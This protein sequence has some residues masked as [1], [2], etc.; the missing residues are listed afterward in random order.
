MPFIR[1]TRVSPSLSF[2][3][4]TTR[5]S[6]EGMLYCR[7]RYDGALT[8]EYK[9]WVK[10]PVAIWPALPP[11]HPQSAVTL[12]ML[13]QIR[14]DHAWIAL[15]L[16]HPTAEA[17]KAAWQSG[18][19]QPAQVAPKSPL[20]L[21]VY[22]TYLLY[23]QTPPTRKK[24]NWKPL[25]DKTLVNHQ[26]VRGHL[27]DF[28]YHNALPALRLSD[29]KPSHGYRF[30]DY[31][32]DRG[33][34]NN[35]ASRYLSYLQKSIT[36]AMR[37]DETI[38]ANPLSSVKIKGDPAKRIDFLTELDLI[39]L[40]TLPLS[41]V[42]GTVRNWSLLMAY[43]GLDYNDCLLVT[44]S[45]GRYYKTADHGDTIV[46]QRLKYEDAPAWG[47]CHI[48]VLPATRELLGDVLN[49]KRVR[50]KVI[51]THLKTI[52]AL[53]KLPFPL[54]SKVFR[55]TAAIVLLLEYEDVFVV[56]KILGHQSVTTLQTYY[57][58][59]PPE[60]VVN[61]MKRKQ[62]RSISPELSPSGYFRNTLS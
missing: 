12:A 20:L 56:Q 60:I 38:T 51:N 5:E 8:T 30:L 52:G 43:T 24:G 55:K 10:V 58:N 15:N 2:R 7:L 28:L 35:T 17:I 13:A 9:I 57:L 37:Y 19:K 14:A 25:A 41:G 27:T 45:L 54:H 4:R 1:T 26:A 36:Y 49:W 40:A 23:L 16:E 32:F 46:F 22:A 11:D 3:L 44:K 48:P 62:K 47:I 59:I 50:L 33:I 29:T 42:L 31:L 39:K 34:S 61:A 21:D 6:G 18:R 53:L